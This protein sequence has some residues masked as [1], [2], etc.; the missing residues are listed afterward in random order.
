VTV[1]FLSQEWADEL[2]RRLNGDP[3]FAEATAG[4]SI[5]IQQTIATDAGPVDYWLTL[6]D[7]VVAL[8]LGT[9]DAPDATIA[10]DYA[11]A[12]GL[13]RREVNPVTAFMLGK[14]KIQ[15]GFA[16]LLD[17]QPALGLLADHMAEMDIR[18]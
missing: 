10:Q 5:K 14:I 17:L 12:V 1:T 8:G 18:F 16:P 9:V 4:R 6:D 2:A 3:A 13:A 15:G 7:G 11:T